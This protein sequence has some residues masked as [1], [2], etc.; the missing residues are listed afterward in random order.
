LTLFPN[1]PTSHI[2][3]FVSPQASSNSAWEELARKVELL[4]SKIQ[5]L[6]LAQVRIEREAMELA[7]APAESMRKHTPSTETEF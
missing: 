3:F 2:G 6:K 1:A 7:D 5:T 4:K